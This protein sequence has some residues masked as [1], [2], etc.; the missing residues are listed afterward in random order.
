MRPLRSSE[1]FPTDAMTW[2]YGVTP[3]LVMYLYLWMTVAEI[4]VTLVSFIHM[5]HDQ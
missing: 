2:S 4:I 5:I 3:R 1:K